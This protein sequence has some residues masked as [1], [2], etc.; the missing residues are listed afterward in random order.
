MGYDDRVVA[1]VAKVA[2]VVS[3]V[4]TVAPQLLHW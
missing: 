3:S 4:T 2:V 1:I